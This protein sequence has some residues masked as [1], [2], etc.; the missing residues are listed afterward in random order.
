LS[1]ANLVPETWELSGDDAWETV[2]HVGTRPL[3]A[4]S[5]ERMRLADGFSHARSLA[6]MTSLV[7]VQGIIVLVGFTAAVGR[8]E[9]SAIISRAVEGAIP[10]PAGE[11]LTAAVSRAADANLAERWFALGFGLVAG[12]ISGTTAM[13]QLERGLNR[14]YG[15]EQDRPTVK[16][17]GRALL[18]ALSVGTLIVGSFFL[19]AF[20][21]SI[22]TSLDNQALN[23][24]W[25]VT[26]WPLGAVLI[27]VAVTLLFRWCP[28]RRQPAPS[29]LAF[30]SLISVGLWSAVTAGLG[31][32]FRA[33]SAFGETYGPLA[34]MVALLLWALLS[35]IS[36][37][38]GASVAA[39][40]EA[41]RA[42]RTD[43][44]SEEKRAYS[45]A[46]RATPH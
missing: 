20:G 3:L 40:L 35:A 33:S 25:A 24:L 14:I 21:Q 18:L 5:F 10:G 7:A 11:S 31:L 27:A 45:A 36:L 17:Y 12:I 23:R 28:S 4:H 43:P 37:L 1:T 9:V 44:Q 30:G 34:G 39:Q 15:V 22:G 32:F 8:S 13:G 29:W 2:R 16:K 46:E 26:R 38:L 42:G 41:V 6:F 19:L